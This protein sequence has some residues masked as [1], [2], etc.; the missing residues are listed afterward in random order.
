M[1]SAIDLRHGDWRDVLAD[2]EVD[3]VIT[4]PPYG[5]R[6][7]KGHDAGVDHTEIGS[8][9][10]DAARRRRLDYTAWAPED[11]NHFVNHWHEHT[12]G[13]ICAMSCSDLFPAWRTAFDRVGR[14]SFAPIPCVIRGM[15]VRLSG[16]GPSSWAVYLN[17]ARPRGK[18]FSTWGTNV[19]AYMTGRGDRSNNAGRIGGKPLRLM[20]AIVRDYSRSGDL[21]CDPCAGYATTAIACA[22]N[23]RRFIGA[24]IDR[25]TYDTALK[26]ITA[27]Q[28]RDLF[29]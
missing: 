24:E 22:A 27:P 19:G 9:R 2:V 8:P 3:C 17:V 13:W 15:S 5:S 11:V 4:D 23:D 18:D 10:W 20:N 21:V 7:H 16:D 25:T 29:A 28:Q 1:T 14:V 12:R 6:T 26:R